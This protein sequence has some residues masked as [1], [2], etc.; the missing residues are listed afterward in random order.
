MDEGN[1]RNRDTIRNVLVDEARQCLDRIERRG[2]A[3]PTGAV[4][5]AKLVEIHRIALRLKVNMPER[6][7]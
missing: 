3:A 1:T 5:Y 2:V 7:G 4:E 6:M